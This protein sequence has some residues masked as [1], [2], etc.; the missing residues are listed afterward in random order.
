MKCSFIRKSKENRHDRFLKKIFGN[1]IV[2]KSWFKKL[3]FN[4]VTEKQILSKLKEISMLEDQKIEPET[5]QAIISASNQDVRNSI[6]TL[7]MHL[8]LLKNHGKSSTSKMKKVS[9]EDANF[10][11][12][13]Y[14]KDT[15]LGIFHTVGK[16]LY[17][18]RIFFYRKI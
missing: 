15:S 7:E 5:L 16:F 18:K 9:E 12:N 17:N 3:K 2:Q 6:I 13:M 4:T 1:E 11:T 10:N 8:I 14:S